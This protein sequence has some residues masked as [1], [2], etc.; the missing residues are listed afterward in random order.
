MATLTLDETSASI[1]QTLRAQAAAKGLSLDRYLSTL[2][3][4]GE[5]MVAAPG[6]SHKVMSRSEF[7]QWILDLTA[8]M[9]TVAPLPADFSRA[10][11]Y[12]D[13]D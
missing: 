4:M 6:S 8:G 7:S 5:R 1:F 12:G 2:A 3:D 11:I 9:P 10:D 13:H